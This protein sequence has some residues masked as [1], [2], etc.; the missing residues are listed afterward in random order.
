MNCVI[1]YISIYFTAQSVLEVVGAT[2]D[3]NTINVQKGENLTL[4]CRSD[5]ESLTLEYASVIYSDTKMINGS[6]MV[7]FTKIAVRDDDNQLVTCRATNATG[8]SLKIEAKVRVQ[9]QYSNFLPP[10]FFFKN[11][12]LKIF[13]FIFKNITFYWSFW[14]DLLNILTVD[15]KITLNGVKNLTEGDTANI[16][17]TVSGSL[18]EPSSVMFVCISS[19]CTSLMNQTSQTINTVYD[20]ASETFTTVLQAA[21]FSVTSDLN[22]VWIICPVSLNGSVL[23]SR[24]NVSVFCKYTN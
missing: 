3:T 5:L 8:E 15:V 19:A 17:C 16:S 23:F 4:T 21:P 22:E 12:D 9:G 11:L 10:I 1:W 24:D 20:N 13:L 2:N 7:S 18:Y 14:F 6:Y